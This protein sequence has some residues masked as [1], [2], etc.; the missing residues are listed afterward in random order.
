MERV[1]NLLRLAH[2]PPRPDRGSR[3]R[4][5]R[6]ADCARGERARIGPH[7]EALRGRVHALVRA[8][9]AVYRSL[10]VAREQRP[11]GALDGGA[12]GA[13]A[14]PPLRAARSTSRV[15]RVV[16]LD[17]RVRATHSRIPR[18]RGRVGV[19]LV[20][21]RRPRETGERRSVVGEVH[22]DVRPSPPRSLGS[23]R[24]RLDA[25][26]VL[27]HAPA[28][29]H[30]RGFHLARRQRGDARLAEDDAGGEGLHRAP[31][32][33]VEV[34]GA[35]HRRPRVEVEVHPR[36]ESVAVGGDEAER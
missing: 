15:H 31:R 28:R 24:E 6:V 14:V 29:A 21:L 23:H 1:G 4:R 3:V 7:A 35:R 11:E 19:V 36:V 34:L 2:H 5:Q 27:V 20:I 16:L 25:R 8:P 9:R 10:L 12:D 18:A 33:V 30:P 13:L 26:A 17:V 32:A 22:P